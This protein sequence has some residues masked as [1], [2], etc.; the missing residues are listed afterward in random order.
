[1][2][3]ATNYEAVVNLSEASRLQSM[4]FAF[5]TARSQ[6]RSVGCA[7]AFARRPSRRWRV[8][9]RRFEAGLLCLQD[10]TVAPIQVDVATARR[11]IAAV[12]YDMLLKAVRV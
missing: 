12:K 5:S 6:P 2:P 4:P 8:D 10:E 7:A 11:P 1:M 3:L 9:Y